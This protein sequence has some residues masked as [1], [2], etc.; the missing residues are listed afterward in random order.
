MVQRYEIT[1]LVDPQVE[2]DAQGEL[3]AQVDSMIADVGGSFE[4]LLSSSRKKMKYPINKKFSLFSRALQVTVDPEKVAGIRAF[5]KKTKGIER[6]MILNTP[7]RSRLRPDI[8]EEKKEPRT[9]EVS[10]KGAKKKV[11]MEEVEK[12]IEEALSE[13]VK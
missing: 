4:E 12:G 3:H 11:T 6:F 1:Y 5:L 2:E 8:F 9:V 10:T 7:K 13:E